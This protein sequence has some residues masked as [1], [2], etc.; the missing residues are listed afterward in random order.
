MAQAQKAEKIATLREEFKNRSGFIFAN[1]RG[2]NV[3]QLNSLRQSLKEKGAHFHV[4]KNRSAKRAFHE[5]G[6]A[7]F[8]GFLIDPTALAYFDGDISDISKIFVESTKETTLQLK[9]GFSRE[10][11]FSPE[12]IQRISKLPPREVLLAQ[13]VGTMNAPV[14]GMVVVLKGLLSTF[15]RTLKA[16]EN[17]KQNS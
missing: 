11:L 17:Q 13:M 10:T 4:V 12:D 3:H 14:S 15:V 1:Y 9:G 5:L 6:F 7:D 16:I 8:D 2:L